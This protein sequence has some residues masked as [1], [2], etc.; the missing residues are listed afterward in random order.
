MPVIRFR[1]A[2]RVQGVGFRAATRAEGARLGLA[3]QAENRADGTVAV[4]ADGDV[5]AI[6]ALARWLQRGP[7]L[8]R[9]TRLERLPA[10]PE[11]T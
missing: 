8:A 2:G 7:A 9:V 10:A 3:V 4:T 11:A 5:A 1:V 6:E